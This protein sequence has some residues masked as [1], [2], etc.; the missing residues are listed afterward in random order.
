MIVSF[1]LPPSFITIAHPVREYLFLF[2]LSENHIT[3]RIILLVVC[4]DFPTRDFLVFGTSLGIS[5]IFLMFVVHD[6]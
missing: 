2:H 4:V 5:S 1:K 6:H 3:I